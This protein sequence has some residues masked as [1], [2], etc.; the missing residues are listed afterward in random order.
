MYTVILFFAL[1]FAP[2]QQQTT[3]IADCLLQSAHTT[4][5]FDYADVTAL[6]GVD[7]WQDMGETVLQQGTVISTLS[8]ATDGGERRIRFYAYQGEL[9]VFV[10]KH[11]SDPGAYYQVSPGVWNWH[12]IC[13]LKLA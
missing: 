13:F 6:A 1:L 11:K 10:W 4:Q 5:M 12:G 7:A 3:T 9:Y 2:A 8:I